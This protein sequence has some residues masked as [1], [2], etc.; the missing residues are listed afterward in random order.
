MN[1]P[2][3]LTS[4]ARTASDKSEVVA[5]CMVFVVVA[6]MV[7]PVPAAFL[8]V[9]IAFNM[10]LSALLVV[11]AVLLPAPL[12]FS[13]FPA[14]LLIS[15][16]FRLSI[17][18]STTRLILLDGYTGHIV[19]AFGEFVIGGNVAVGIIV[20]LIIAVV[21][22]IVVT[23]GSERVAEVAARFSLDGMP[24]K[25]MS[26]DSD[27][28]AGVID[29]HEAKS[30]RQR[31]ERESQLFGAMDGAIKFV[32]GDAIA[33]FIIVFI[34]LL[35]GL[36]IGMMQKGMDFATAGSRY[37]LLSVGDGLVA[38]IPSLMV[39]IAAGMIVTRVGKGDAQSNSVASDMA[40]EIVGNPRAL[41][42]AVVF[43]LAF[44]AI[45]GMPGAVFI[46]MA[47]SLA[48]PWYFLR[49]S[50]LT[51]DS[52]VEHVLPVAADFQ[53]RVNDVEAPPRI[54][55]LIVQLSGALA[56]AQKTILENICRTARNRLLEQ[57]GVNV[58][59]LEFRSSA[60]TTTHHACLYMHEVPMLNFSLREGQHLIRQWGASN[61]TAVNETTESQTAANAIATDSVMPAQAPQYGDA[62]QSQAPA[63]VSGSSDA[64]ARFITRLEEPLRGSVLYLV[65]REHVADFQAAGYQLETW[66]SYLVESLIDCLLTHAKSIFSAQE[67]SNWL[68]AQESLYPDVVKELQR[69]LPNARLHEILLRLLSER[70][71]ILNFEAIAACLT[72]WASR[73]R[74]LVIL[75]EHV[76]MALGAQIC[77]SASHAGVVHGYVISPELEATV[78]Q[79]L[80]QTSSGS[81]LDLDD[82]TR[83]ALIRHIHA[84]VPFY[85]ASGAMPV[86]LAPADCRRYV[87]R[88]YD[89]S[90]SW[91]QVISFSE[92][93]PHVNVT[94]VGEVGGV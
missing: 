42:I 11:I 12:A 89:Q 68:L 34:N 3:T 71:S 30:R 27:L 90:M 1:L 65:H 85:L 9:C 47:C 21:N 60:Q 86:L 84:T 8:D 23:K 58:P 18:V 10:T 82:E 32:K 61:P 73:E 53:Q 94:V 13:S 38:L 35:G 77:H 76:R 24:G 29:Q 56:P 63:D 55:P 16:L 41:L 74:D 19:E 39:S 92:V 36:T 45:P 69:V 22:F 4:W 5:A 33:G 46:G 15:T 81:Y 91:L 48:L 31:L 64:L 62:V 75:S 54:R 93:P 80:R 72:E 6:M 67:L 78:R 83:N 79:A 25:Q 2:A 37:S 87:R 51:T 20:F 66:E 59:K 28:R 57:Y 14:V 17:S 40:K 44:A 52:S 49:H 26:I 70:V 88:L 50:L 7:I 43:A